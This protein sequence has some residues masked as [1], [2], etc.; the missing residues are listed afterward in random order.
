K[1]K[2][3][4]ISCG[5]PLTSKITCFLPKPQVQASQL[6]VHISYFLQNCKKGKFPKKDLPYQKR[7][8]NNF[9]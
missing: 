7:Y 4:T 1:N 2:A 9:L 6:P 3:D 8:H 5:P